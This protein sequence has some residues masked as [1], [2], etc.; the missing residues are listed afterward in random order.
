MALPCRLCFLDHQCRRKHDLVCLAIRKAL[1]GKFFGKKEHRAAAL[2]S[3]ELLSC[4]SQQ[5]VPSD[6]RRAADA[7]DIGCGFRE[8]EK[9]LILGVS[10][11]NIF[12]V[13][14]LSSLC[15]HVFGGHAYE[16]SPAFK[17][18]EC[19]R[20][21]FCFEH[22][23]DRTSGDARKFQ[24]RFMGSSRHD[25][26]SFECAAERRIRFALIPPERAFKND[27]RVK[28]DNAFC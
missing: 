15:E 10:A 5:F 6:E 23:F 13:K 26:P 22:L 9:L 12:R 8:D 1:F 17:H 21:R 28:D 18:G 25:P 7:A 20:G 27:V 4:F 3:P 14:R 24:E 11:A 16:F 2:G 19:A